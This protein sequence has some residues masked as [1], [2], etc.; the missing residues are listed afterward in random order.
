MSLVLFFNCLPCIS[1][2]HGGSNLLVRLHLGRDYAN[3]RLCCSLRTDK[4][5]TLHTSKALAYEIKSVPRI[6]LKALFLN[7]FKLVGLIGSESRMPS[8]IRIFEQGTNVTLIHSDQL[9]FIKTKTFERAKHKEAFYCIFIHV[10]HL[11]VPFK[12]IL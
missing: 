12:V 8:N 10:V 6:I 2:L 11:S 9:R 1:P 4:R 3:F 7:S 5:P